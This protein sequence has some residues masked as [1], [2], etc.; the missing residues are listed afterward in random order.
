MTIHLDQ[1]LFSNRLF[2]KWLKA[3]KAGLFEG[4]FFWGK[5]Q[6]DSSLKRSKNLAKAVNI[7]EENLHTFRTT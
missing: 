1:I 7:D 6:F 2:K 3:N 5:N 4:S